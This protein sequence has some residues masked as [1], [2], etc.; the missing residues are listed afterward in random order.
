MYIINTLPPMRTHP[1][2]VIQGFRADR[3]EGNKGWWWCIHWEH[4]VGGF[5]GYLR[6]S[7]RAR[8]GFL[9]R[10]CCGPVVPRVMFTQILRRKQMCQRVPSL[11]SIR[12]RHDLHTSD[13]SS[14]SS[15]LESIKGSAPGAASGS[16]EPKSLAVEAASS[17][18]LTVSHSV[19]LSPL[20]SCSACL[21]GSCAVNF[22][23]F[24]P[25]YEAVL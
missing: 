22:D 19:S 20:S 10:K 5:Q 23:G 17:L 25:F 7:V 15:R 8:C 21:L 18:V 14:S 4:G 12:S 9:N 2:T 3:R 6:L 24:P 16:T 1:R 13:S 11:F